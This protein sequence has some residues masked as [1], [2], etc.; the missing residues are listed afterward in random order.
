VLLST[1]VVSSTQRGIGGRAGQQ[2]LRL[3]LQERGK[4]REEVALLVRGCVPP[5]ALPV[6]RKQKEAAVPLADGVPGFRFAA[7]GLQTQIAI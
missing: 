6:V 7:S 1:M 4:L 2:R 3:G 5:R